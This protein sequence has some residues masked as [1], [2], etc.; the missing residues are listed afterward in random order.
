[1]NCREWSIIPLV[2]NLSRQSFPKRRYGTRRISLFKVILISREKILWLHF[3]DFSILP[4]AN[5][6]S[7]FVNDV[8]YNISDGEITCLIPRV[9]VRS[10]RTKKKRIRM[11]NNKKQILIIFFENVIVSQRP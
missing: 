1:M 5:E 4:H 11:R 3:S 8:V 10:K 7:R 6:T 2:I 9:L